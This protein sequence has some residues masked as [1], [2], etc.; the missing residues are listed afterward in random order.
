[1]NR[2][3]ILAFNAICPILAGAVIYYLISPEVIFVKKIDA[4]MGDIVSI[5]ITPADHFL[6]KLVRNYFLDMLWGY[7]FVFALFLLM[8]NSTVK[9]GKL[10]AISFSFSAVMEMI[11]IAP[12]VHGTF[13]I[14]D[15]G[16]EFLAEVFAVFIINT[17][18]SRE[19]FQNE[20]GN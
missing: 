6:F 3:M 18:Y 14:W 9:R 8:G 19:E 16:V 15:I 4:F 2:K 11:Q 17:I 12:S 1:M 20:K 7:A 13:D 10:L 5:H